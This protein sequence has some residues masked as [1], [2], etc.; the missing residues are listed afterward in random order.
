MANKGSGFDG[1]YRKS[2]YSADGGANCVEVADLPAD[3]I[4]ALRDTQ[5]R[6]LGH[7]EVDTSTFTALLAAVK[8]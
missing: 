3:R 8:N 5:N 7:L 1:L 4:H 2:S 6:E